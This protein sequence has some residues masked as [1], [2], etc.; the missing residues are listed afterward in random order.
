MKCLPWASTLVAL[1]A[2]TAGALAAS[3]HDA[4]LAAKHTA[5]E[6]NFRNDT[7][8]LREAV[9][10]FGNLGTDEILATRALYHAAWTEWM[11]TA[12]LLDARNPGD[13]VAALESGI[14]RLNQLLEIQPDDGEAHGLLSWMLMALAFSDQARAKT[15]F[16]QAL[17][18]RKRA[19]ELAPRSPRVVMLDATLMFYSPQPGMQEKA[20]ARW[21]ET[22]ELVEGETITDPMLPDWGR[23]LADGWLANLYI[24]MT[25]PRTGKA[26]THAEKALRERPDFWWV[27]TRVIPKI[28]ESEEAGN[29]G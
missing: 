19:L 16:P 5:T 20:L 2:V 3:P 8:G 13:A 15:L 17:E 27:T 22:L 24:S 6:A 1:L 4:F 9:A 21:Q 12:S 7:E 14:A 18:H 28:R 11:L 10:I 29:G 25:P 26:R 23:T